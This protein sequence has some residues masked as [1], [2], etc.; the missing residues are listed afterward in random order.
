MKK[1][2]FYSTLLIT[3]LSFFA[4]KNNFIDTDLIKIQGGTFKMGSKDS[5][6][7]ADVDEQ[8]EHTVNLNT[9]EISKF[10]VTVSDFRAFVNA[11]GYK[12]DAE[13]KGGSYIFNGERWET[14]KG[15]NWRFDPSG[16]PRSDMEDNH[17]VVHVSWNDAQAYCNWLKNATGK[18]YRLP[19]EAEWEYAA[20]G[21]R[22]QS[23]Y[24]WGGYYLR[25]K[26]GC[27][28]ANHG[29]LV[30]GRD[31]GEALALCV[32]VRQKAGHLGAEG[33]HG[34]LVFA[35]AELLDEV[36]NHHPARGG[37]A[38]Q[39]YEVVGHLHERRV[40]GHEGVQAGLLRRVVGGGAR[41]QA[42]DDGARQ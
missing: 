40:V 12:T 17:P 41:G 8:K 28:L 1:I 30:A 5:D 21:G 6:G 26:K 27:L 32:F 37:V 35:G 11:T 13:K 25:S 7:L 16:S 34:R 31:L 33:I 38:A 2:T 3:L 20:R 15:V 39:L 4:F 18:T 29:Q 24:P 22:S 23:P 19:T 36:F 42:R 10:E 9:F 14:K